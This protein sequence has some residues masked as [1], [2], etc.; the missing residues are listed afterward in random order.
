MH[1]KLLKL[2]FS[3]PLCVFKENINP[4]GI[5]IIKIYLYDS[6]ALKKEHSAV[7]LICIKLPHGFK[8]FGL[9]IFEWLLKTGFTVTFCWRMQTNSP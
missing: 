2:S 7:L 5:G 3:L 1:S 4:F 8:T 9:S 6:P